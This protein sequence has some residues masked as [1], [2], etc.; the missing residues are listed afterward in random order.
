MFLQFAGNDLSQYFMEDGTPKT[1]VNLLGIEV[2]VFP[3]VAEKADV[4]DRKF[5]TNQ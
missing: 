1:R 2:P 5:T 4:D 3:P